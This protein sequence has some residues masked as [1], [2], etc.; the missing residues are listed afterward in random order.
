MR[1]RGYARVGRFPKILSAALR[2]VGHE[3]MRVTEGH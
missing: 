3:G 1:E 2:E